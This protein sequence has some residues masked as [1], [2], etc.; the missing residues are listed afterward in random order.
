MFCVD[1]ITVLST[2]YGKK[3]HG[4]HNL[5]PVKEAASHVPEVLPTPGGI[6]VAQLQLLRCADWADPAT[7]LVSKTWF[8][9]PFC[10]I[11]TPSQGLLYTIFPN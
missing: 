8:S 7:Q 10:F 6:S 2:P 1:L 4:R 3:I 9:Q 5:K 11:I